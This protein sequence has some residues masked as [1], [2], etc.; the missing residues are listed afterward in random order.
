MILLRGHSLTPE[1]KIPLESMSLQLKERDSTATIVPA[2]MTGIELNS[3][4]QDETEPGKGIVW[5]VRSTQHAYAARATTIQLEHMIGSLRDMLLFG[6]VKP[7][8]IT[9]NSKATTCTAEQAV[10]YILSFQS[11]WV[12]G[13]FDYKNVS[14]PYKFDGDSLY[15]AL[16]TVT[17]SLK[18][19]WWS[20][21]MSVYPFRL[22]IT[23]KP[24]DVGTE[25]RAGRNL[26][27]I[28][29]TIDKSGMFTRFYPIG[30]DDLHISG[31]FAQKNTQYYGV[32][33]KVETD[34]S[35][36]TAAE[37]MRWANEQLDLHADPMITIDVEGLELADAT[38]V[39]LDRMQLGKFCRVP[40]PEFGTEITERIVTMNYPDK[41]HQ[42]EV[43]KI[44]LA[45]NRTDVTKIIA[46]TI[47]SGGK[48]KRTST[49]QNKEDHAWFEDTN[50][51]VAMCAKAVIGT[52]AKGN[53][54]WTRLSTLKVDENGI[55][56]EVKSMQ[57]ELVVAQTKITQNE[58][59]I[60]LEAR[61]ATAK[62][63]ELSARIT[64][65]AEGIETKVSK[66]GVISSINQTSESIT[67]QAAKVNLSGYVTASELATTNATINNLIS[68]NTAAA[69]IKANQLAASSSFSLKGHTHNNSII[70]IDGVNFNIVTWSS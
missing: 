66:N 1:K 46:E 2:E 52:D 5:R 7:A 47:K 61:R 42:P 11:D 48:G 13:A 45:N 43:V 21:D 70:T 49:K 30:K 32:V 67:I 19:A 10:R 29:R 12:L 50:T 35:I 31:N 28:S 51:H 27:T 14:N 60:T 33:A 56:G 25:M 4:V 53:P 68:G 62:E 59:A 65:N 18:D 40:L 57:G 26:R 54:N 41:V 38:G 63:G 23:K 58:N 9:K 36:E 37:L 15:D 16:E 24:A 69:S 6:E 20:Y 34:A 3:W 44:T 22:N 17:N 64:V 8:T 55:S 39:S